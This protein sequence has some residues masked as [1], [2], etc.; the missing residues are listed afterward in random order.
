MNDLERYFDS[1][2][3]RMIHKWSH[4]FEIYDRH[5]ARYRGT[6]AHLVEIGVYQG[7]SLQM[8]KAYLGERATIWGIDVNPPCAQFAEDRV[9]IIIGDQ[10]DPAFLRSVAQRVP[11]I[12]ILIDDGGHTMRQQ[13]TTFETLYSHVAADGIYICEDLHTSY[14]AEY[15]GGHLQPWSFIEYSKNLIDWLNAWHSREASLPVSDFTRSTFSLHYYDSMLVVERRRRE[16]PADRRTGMR[17]LPDAAFPP[18]KP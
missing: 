6:D 9:E 12:N 4:Y 5:L 17:T 11:R 14:W 3:G 15:G 1:N 16:A 2:P 7:G 8:W 13:R 10:A 18:P